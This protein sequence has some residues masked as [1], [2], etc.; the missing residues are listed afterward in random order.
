MTASSD[1]TVAVDLAEVR[2]GSVR[3]LDVVN[4]FLVHRSHLVRA[5]LRA[6][7]QQQPDFYVVGDSATASPGA[8]YAV[9]PDVVVTD[10]DLPDADGPEVMALLRK[11][12]PEAALLVLTRVDHPAK[13]QRVLEAG[14]DG[15][16]LETAPT[17]EF[18]FGIRSV[19]RGE[20]YL[21]PSIGVDLVRWQRASS[22]AARS[23]DQLSPKELEVLRLL[24]LGHTNAEIAEIRLVSLRTVEAQ[25]ARIVQK[26]G[27]GRRA[28]LV[29]Y[30]HELGIVD[31]TAA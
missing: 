21:Q 9:T 19:A 6:L 24:A 4:L 2:G 11:E 10:V 20:S 5:G 1:V 31:F 15:Y 3:S 23:V 28:E 18:C 22:N 14:A 26:L 25:R 8:A 27:R 30:A 17:S 29:A 12:F 13:V 7:A 16:M